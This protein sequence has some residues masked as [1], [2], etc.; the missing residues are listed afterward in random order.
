ME[1]PT[2]VPGL[3]SLGET[4][5][6]VAD[7]RKMLLY[8]NFPP[9]CV[10]ERLTFCKATRGKEHEFI[11]L[12][13][14]HWNTAVPATARLIVERALNPY[15][16]DRRSMMTSFSASQFSSLISPTSSPTSAIDSVLIT[17][18]TV[19]PHWE[20]YLGGRYGAYK[21]LCTLEFSATSCPSATQISVLLFVINHHAPDY[22]LWKSQCYWFSRTIWETIK[23]LFSGYV[24]GAWKPGRSQCFGFNVVDMGDS[25]KVVCLEYADEWTRFDNEN[26][27]E[28]Q[29]EQEKQPKQK[30][31]AEL[32]GAQQ[33]NPWWNRA[34]MTMLQLWAASYGPY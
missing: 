7:W 15:P 25:V 30:C 10:L 4:Q 2:D 17:S 19:H 33:V 31:Q 23:Q 32:A 26:E 12:Y 34:A 11:V 20:R 16:M 22:H 5:L 13:F 28:K 1:Y 18:N 9:R 27:K 3:F 24:E 8:S 14:R 29:L 6:N 21:T